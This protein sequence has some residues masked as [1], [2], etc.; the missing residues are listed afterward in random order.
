MHG[1]VVGQ[2]GATLSRSPLP[3]LACFGLAKVNSSE[4]VG[5]L[6]GP[7]TPK[8]GLTVK[9]PNQNGYGWR[10]T[11]LERLS[12]VILLSIDQL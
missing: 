10:A 1:T 5:P 3:S 4:G 7:I 11:I 12:R 2:L 9:S 6:S 8:Y